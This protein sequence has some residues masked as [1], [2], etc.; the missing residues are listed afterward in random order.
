MYTIT[1]ENADVP[2]PP[3]YT[4]TPTDSAAVVPPPYRD[5]AGVG[6]YL[7]AR[8]HVITTQQMEVVITLNGRYYN[9]MECSD[10]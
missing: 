7:Q 4:R 3:V 2:P 9:I 8:T 6:R 10:E 1:S 5:T